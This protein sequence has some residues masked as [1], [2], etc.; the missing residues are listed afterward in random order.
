[1]KTKYIFL[2]LAVFISSTG[3]K[4][5]EDFCPYQKTLKGSWGYK[6]FPQSPVKLSFLKDGTY[7]LDLDADGS[8]DIWGVYRSSPDRIY[9]KDTGGNHA[10]DCG[11]DGVYAYQIKGGKADYTLIADKCE[12]RVTALSQIWVRK[13]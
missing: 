2:I 6:D 9:L 4:T 3:C 13:K 12:F 10:P 1:M 7:E 11:F 5:L 8:R